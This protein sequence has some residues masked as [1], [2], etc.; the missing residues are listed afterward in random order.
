MQVTLAAKQA[1]VGMALIQVVALMT[2]SCNQFRLASNQIRNPPPV[3][4]TAAAHINPSAASDVW[5]RTLLLAAV[6]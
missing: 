6:A 4:F 2:L 1:K 5:P 3:G